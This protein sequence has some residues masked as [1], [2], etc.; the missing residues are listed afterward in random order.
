MFNKIKRKILEKNRIYPG[1]M[2]PKSPRVITQD[3]IDQEVKSGHAVKSDRK[4][5]DHA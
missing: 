5:N 3:D 2:K 4:E 1:G